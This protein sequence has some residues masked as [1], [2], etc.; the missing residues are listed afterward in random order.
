MRVPKPHSKPVRRTPITDRALF[1]GVQ[2]D[3]DEARTTLQAL[4]GALPV[5]TVRQLRLKP[6]PLDPVVRERR[7]PTGRPLRIGPALPPL[8]RTTTGIPAEEFRFELCELKGREVIQVTQ[9]MRVWEAYAT[10]GRQQ[11]LWHGHIL[12]PAGTQAV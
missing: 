3:S 10:F 5:R 8:Q 6:D 9:A 12:K 2:W 4:L 1:S 11:A 7:R